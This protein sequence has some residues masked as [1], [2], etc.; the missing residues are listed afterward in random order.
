MKIIDFILNGLMETNPPSQ[1]IYYISQFISIG[2]LED[3]KSIEQRSGESA[4]KHTMNV[5]DCLVI[6]NPITL[7]SA[8]FHDAGKFHTQT[9]DNG[10]INFW[11][12]ETISAEI[13]WSILPSWET[14]LEVIDCV[15]RII[16]TH[17]IDIKSNM[18]RSK[19]RRFIAEVGYKNIPNW[20]VLRR[21][22]ALSY[23]GKK[24]LSPK[25]YKN[26]IIDPFEKRVRIELEQIYCGSSL[27]FDSS[28]IGEGMKISGE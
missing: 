9:I 5:L 27:K 11:E 26:V 12:H 7:L 8:L 2:F 14:H 22:D 6:K 24:H 16:K 23:L 28:I 19:V 15:A 20:F 18:T 21:A 1:S 4:F 3:L 17:M 25:Q 13:A 10:K